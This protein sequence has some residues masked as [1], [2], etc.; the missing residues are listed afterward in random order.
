MKTRKLV[1]ITIGL[2]TGLI[3]SSGCATTNK[4]AEPPNE[5]SMLLIGRVTLTCVNFPA[6]WHVKGNYT[7]KITVDL[8][9]RTTNAV[10]RV[11]SK[12]SDGFFYL[13][14]SP[15]PYEVVGFSYETR[16]GRRRITLGIRFRSPL[17]ITTKAGAVNNL[18]D[19]QWKEKYETKF[20]TKETVHGSKTL[21]M[22]KK[23]FRFMKNYRQLERW[24]QKTYPDSSWN[25]EEWV[26]VKVLTE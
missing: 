12:G 5:D 22:T 17:P 2:L 6:N 19:I 9:N 1:M 15:G 16:G 4:I 10:V 23:E 20:G 13:L 11:R 8:K 24:F 21:G 26:D 3:V 25:T 18:G 7:R 14:D